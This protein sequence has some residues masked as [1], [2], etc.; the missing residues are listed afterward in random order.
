MASR[1]VARLL[2]SL[3]PSTKSANMPILSPVRQPTDYTMLGV[4]KKA[5]ESLTPGLKKLLQEAYAACGVNTY[6]Q[7]LT[8]DI[9]AIEFLKK[10]GTIIEP[11]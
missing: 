2:T 7:A 4:N 5:W 3:S 10:Y 11:R 8:E 6:A 1:Q 9:K